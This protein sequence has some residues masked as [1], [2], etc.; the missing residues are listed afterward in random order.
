MDAG[1]AVEEASPWRGTD[2]LPCHTALL[3]AAPERALPEFGDK[4]AEGRQRPTIGRHRAVVKVSGDDPIQPFSLHGNRLMSASSQFLFDGLQ[5]RSHAV[6]LG[7]PFDLEFASARLAADEGEA[8]EIEGLRL[9]QPALPAF[10][11]A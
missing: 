7:F 9:A 4:E 8:Q 5:L 3:T 2:S 11:A 10:F 1:Y 6:T